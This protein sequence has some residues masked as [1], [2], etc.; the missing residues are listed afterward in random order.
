[1]SEVDCTDDEMLQEYLDWDDGVRGKFAGMR[2]SHH[3]TVA[4]EVARLSDG[5]WCAGSAEFPD[6]KGFGADPKSSLRQA[7]ARI[8][9]VVADRVARGEIPPTGLNF[10]IDYS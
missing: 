1:M 4:I 6:V 2:P 9:D 10:A 5:R 7:Q 3:M 8:A